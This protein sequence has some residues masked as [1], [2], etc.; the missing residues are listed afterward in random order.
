MA[1]MSVFRSDDARAAYGKV[2]DAAVAA[3]TVPV[4]ES[5]VET[6]FGRTHV[7]AAGDPSK[8]PLVAMHGMQLS[9]TSWLPLLPTLAAAHRVTMIDAVGQVSKSIATKPLI[10]AAHVVAWLDETLRA[11][12]IERPAIVG[13]SFGSWIATHYAMAHPE[14][15][16]RLALNAPVGLVSGLRPRVLPRFYEIGIRP[17]QARVELFLEACVTPAGLGRLRQ[18]PWQLIMQQCVVGMTGFKIAL[19]G[20]IRPTRCDLGPLAAAQIPVL[21]IVGRDEWL[22]DGPKMAAR[23]RRRLPEARIEIVDGANHIIPID[24]PQ[25]VEKLLADFLH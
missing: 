22:H 19:I 14:R 9:A 4:V 2:Y 25:I 1:G 20:G 16:D 5:D 10:K 15:V 17:S 7:L 8:P 3:S 18:D 13:L 6:S 23:F 21:V 11:L 12:R 24:Q